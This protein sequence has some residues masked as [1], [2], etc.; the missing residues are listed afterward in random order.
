MSFLR[1]KYGNKRCKGY[2]S[3]REAGR[4]SELQLLQ[5]CGEI[6]GLE[7][8]VKYELIPKQDGERAC[9]YICDFRYRDAAGNLVVEDSKGFKTPDYII[10]RKLMLKVHGIKVQEV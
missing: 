3:K 8:Q 10:K 7:F 4:A 2:A 9:H 6:S 5:K 1:G